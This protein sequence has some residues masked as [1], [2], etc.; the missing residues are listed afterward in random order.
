M[1][2]T[3]SFQYYQKGADPDTR[4]IVDKHVRKIDDYVAQVTDQSRRDFVVT[5]GRNAAATYEQLRGEA[6][7]ELAEHR[8]RRLNATRDAIKRN[9][10]AL[11]QKRVTEYDKRNY[12]L[13][14]KLASDEELSQRVA[15]IRDPEGALN[16]SL[17]FTSSADLEAYINELDRRPK[18]REHIAPAV[19]KAFKETGAQ[20]LDLDDDN[21]LRSIDR[22]REIEREQPGEIRVNLFDVDGETV[23]GSMPVK[24]DALTNKS[25]LEKQFQIKL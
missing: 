25:V 3:N 8:E 4:R 10:E 14:Y 21:I 6:Y 7:R 17:A 23:K 11:K 24:F 22:A 15:F 16:L 13:K 1:A 18:L 19:S 12:A 5:T 2:K 9:R 20:P